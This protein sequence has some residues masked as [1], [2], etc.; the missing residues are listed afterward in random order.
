M[1]LTIE[2]PDNLDTA[3][4][5]HA[6]AQGVSASDFVQQVLE[7]VLAPVSRAASTLELPILHLGAMDALHR[8]D[9]YKDVR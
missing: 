3:L 4:H 5:T 2:L 8:R 7:Q 9:I 1:T 6:R